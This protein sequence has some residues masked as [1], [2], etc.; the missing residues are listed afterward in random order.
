MLHLDSIPGHHNTKKVDK[1]LR[2]FLTYYHEMQ[3]RILSP[4]TEANMPH[5]ALRVPRQDDGCSCAL[6]MLTCVKKLIESKLSASPH[7]IIHNAMS[8][9]GRGIEMDGMPS[10]FMG[11]RWFSI[12]EA[13]SLRTHMKLLFDGYFRPV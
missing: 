6:F 2:S 8:N 5:Y 9:R 4:F 13:K 11:S 7:N 10:D 1:H 3:N 12:A